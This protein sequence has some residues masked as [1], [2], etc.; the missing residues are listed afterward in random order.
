[1]K[2][3]NYFLYLIKVHL[4]YLRDN[5][6]CLQPSFPRT[7]DRFTRFEIVDEIF[8]QDPYAYA[9]MSV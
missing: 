4:H 8:Y 2:L 6:V 7:P 1:M 9:A 3:L 5:R